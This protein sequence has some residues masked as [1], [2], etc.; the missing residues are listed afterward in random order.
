MTSSKPKATHAIVPEEYPEGAAGSVPL[1][2]SQRAASPMS[3]R[4]ISSSER[5]RG[6]LLT[7]RLPLRGGLVKK[8]YSLAPK[9]SL[10]GV[11]SREWVMS[12]VPSN[13]MAR[14]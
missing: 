1:P 4:G 2:N 10:K 13:A 14:P 9:G 5:P 3:M 7:I 11:D 6:Y 12:Q 8:P